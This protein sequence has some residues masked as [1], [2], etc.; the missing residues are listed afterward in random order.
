[1]RRSAIGPKLP[2][3]V[4]P[5]QTLNV[6]LVWEIEAPTMERFILDLAKKKPVRFTA[7]QLCNFTTNYSTRLGSCGFGIVYKGQ[8]PNGVKIAVKVIG[9]R[10]IEE[11]RN[12]SW[13][14]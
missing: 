8:F 3:T 10:I 4:A 9:N 7:Q 11:Q 12:N 5:P 6:V 14:R 2:T 13:Q 1:M